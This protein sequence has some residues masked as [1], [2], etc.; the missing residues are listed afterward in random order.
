MNEKFTSPQEIIQL[1]IEHYSNLLKTPLDEQ[2]RLTVE[3]LLAAE[4]AKLAE[5]AK[6]AAS[7]AEDLPAGAKGRR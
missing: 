2:T 4:K 5:L 1:N 3:G 6:A 7:P